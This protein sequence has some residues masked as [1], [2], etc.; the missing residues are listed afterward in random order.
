MDFALPELG[1][2]VYEGELVRWLVKPG[3]RVKR[4]QALL[5]IMTDKALME[6]PAPF[7]GRITDIQFEPGQTIKV[8]TR[9]LGYEVGEST[10]AITADAAPPA[11]AVP[12]SAAPPAAA[13][14]PGA[15]SPLAAVP[16]SAASPAAAVPAASTDHTARPVTDV[17]RDRT[18]VKNGSTP[19][20][21]VV[22]AVKASPAVRYMARKL[23]IDLA[24]VRGSGPGGRILLDDLT[25]A[26][27]AT[28]G[29]APDTPPAPTAKPQTTMSLD[30]GTPGTRVKL[31]GLR[32]R[33]AERM[34]QSK[35]TIPHYTY[36]DEVEI[37]DLVRWRDRSVEFFA[38]RG[39]K[40]TYLAFFVK[41]A[42]LALKE[43]PIVN[44]TFDEERQEITLHDRYH[45]GIAVA[46]PGGL[47]VPVIRDADRLDLFAIA[48]EIE[49]LSTAARSGKATREE[50]TGSTFTITSIGGIGGIISTPIIN[51]PEVGIL[52]LG[53]VVKR[54]VYDEHGQ[55]RPADVIYLSL[56][57]DHRVVDGAVGATFGNALVRHLKQPAALIFGP[58]FS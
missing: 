41:A 25:E 40:L 23:G 30:L 26:I 45:I 57:F 38:E 10:T 20:L 37:T 24:R 50:L 29:K 42:A 27:R 8:G 3:D 33:I 48:R 15:A 53:K 44:S 12:P 31:A 39:I 7:A 54:P 1:E 49:R 43:V 18:A 5:E 22:A 17:S 51:L 11:A 19:T 16:P 4:G 55:I 28:Q 35:R 56:S 58:N 2:G 52:G 46:A 47:L 34:V 14:P 13:I 21:A 32:R 9:I 6:V 36:V